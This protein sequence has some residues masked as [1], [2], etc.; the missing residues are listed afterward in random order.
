MVW[1][2]GKEYACNSSSYD[3]VE[4]GAIRNIFYFI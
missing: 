2:A 3:E 4:W 1:K